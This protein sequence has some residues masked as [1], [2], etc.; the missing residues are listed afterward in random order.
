MADIK[1]EAV[2]ENFAAHRTRGVRRHTL[3]ELI[4]CQL[5]TAVSYSHAGCRIYQICLI[6]RTWSDAWKMTPHQKHVLNSTMAIP[7]LPNPQAWVTHDP[8]HAGD[9]SVWHLR[10][11]V[12]QGTGGG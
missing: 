5:T 9:G 1:Q 3:E 11:A 10:P 2:C 8:S 4:T 6:R 7:D 12:G